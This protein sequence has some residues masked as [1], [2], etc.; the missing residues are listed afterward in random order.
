MSPPPY[1][2]SMSAHV[3]HMP[4]Y[5]RHRE[6]Q[7]NPKAETV[8]AYLQVQ[9]RPR[10]HSLSPPGAQA[11]QE[12]PRPATATSAHDPITPTRAHSSAQDRGPAQEQWWRHWTHTQ[13]RKMSLISALDILMT[14]CRFL[15]WK[16]QN[17]SSK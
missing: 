2:P 9:I 13:L 10:P 14:F 17:Q 4:R 8:R 16:S 11:Y 5:R 3:Q 6:S 15:M 7:P 12:S 1:Q